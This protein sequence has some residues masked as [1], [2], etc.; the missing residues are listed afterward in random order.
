[1]ASAFGFPG[2]ARRAADCDAHNLPEILSPSISFIDR[3]SPQ[4]K[5][6]RGKCRG[7]FLVD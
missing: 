5:K 2:I 6:A 7:L 4:Q 1:V 3:H